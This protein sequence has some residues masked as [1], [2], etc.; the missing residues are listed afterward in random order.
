[1]IVGM[2]RLSLGDWA[3]CAF[4]WALLF[5]LTACTDPVERPALA[6]VRASV[7]ADSKVRKDAAVVEI[8]LQ[9][10]KRGAGSKV[11]E[12]IKPLQSFYPTAAEDW[13]WSYTLATDESAYDRF[14]L[15]ATALDARRS[16]VGSVLVIREAAE[17]RRHGLRAHFDAACYRREACEPGFTCV[18]G[19]CVD[20]T[21][22]SAAPAADGGTPTTAADASTDTHGGLDEGLATAGHACKTGQRACDGHGSLTPLACEDGVWKEQPACAE[23]QRCST[24]DGDTLGSCQTIAEA[25]ANRTANEPYC[26]GETMY[27][28]TD[29][30]SAVE[31]Q[32]PDNE[33]CAQK[34]DSAVCD[35][36]AG[37]VRQSDG[38]CKQSKA[39]EQMNGGCDPLTECSLV[40]NDRVC[41]SCPPGYTGRGE[42]GCVPQLQ[43]VMLSQGTLDRKFT[44]AERDYRVQVPLVGQRVTFT[45]HAPQGTT[46][47]AN[48]EALDANGSWTSPALPIGETKVELMPRTA[49][50][51]NT[52]YSF[53]LERAGEQVERIKP[54]N[55]GSFNQFGTD[56]DISGDTLV[57]TSWF[58]DSAA[59]GI[60]GDENDTGAADSGAAW[61]YVR[62][63]TEWKKQAYIKPN[64]TMTL[65]YFGT[66]ADIQGDTLVVGAI[67][68]GIFE[69]GA[70][71]SRP[72]AAYVFERKDGK[73]MQ[74][75]RLAASTMQA[76]SD[77]F[78]EAIT[79]NGDTLAVGAP[80]DSTSAGTSGA[81]YIYQRNGSMFS[82]V[83][84]IKATKPVQ[85]AGF[86]SQISIDGD[87]M[88]I[89]APS[90]PTSSTDGGSAEVFVRS[91]GMWKSVQLIQPQIRAGAS[92]GYFTA[93]R[94]NTL[95]ISAPRPSDYPGSP[96]PTDP[97][98]VYVYEPDGEMWK[99][100]AVLSAPYPRNTNWFGLSV[101]LTDA[102]LIVGSPGD[103]S[104]GRGVNAD[105]SKAG[106]ATFSGAV[107]LFAPSRDGWK[108]TA[109]IKG[110][111]TDVDDW[112]GLS[113]EADGDWLAVGAMFE[114]DMGDGLRAGAV[115]LFH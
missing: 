103:A 24:A 113:V 68:E 11:W 66:H 69:G 61:V 15:R 83:Q 5:A 65:D 106:N 19:A 47:T 32:C 26:D 29:L 77:L 84:K 28:C 7:D 52:K 87:R 115:Y 100:A 110:N 6:P 38:R 12:A 79:L 67:H 111:E 44:P 56:V 20:A 105:P 17:A 75:Q 96:T 2:S 33:W 112:F 91:N 73:W 89:G 88:V 62:D 81:V 30:T 86:G 109:F 35:C 22:T 71:S 42:T 107:Y 37:Y 58:E 48:S 95:A 14:S 93:L 82:E 85:G 9:G 104:N 63:G 55:P 70:G 54:P 74:T 10:Q 46:V 101:Y 90:T 94:G 72:G 13:P 57:I 102:G 8:E 98:E 51:V 4:A 80:W 3:M 97:G 45:P 64:D 114:N 99:Q 76:S 31:R 53:T 34:G 60:N 25:C 49:F 1:M 78:G 16:V 59:K 92:F 41:S 23:N 40:S 36:R 50:G 27:I 18:D 39:C 21:S 43:D 108:Q